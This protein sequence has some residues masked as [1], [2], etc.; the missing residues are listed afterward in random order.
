MKLVILLIGVLIIVV[1]LI[2]D[3]MSLFNDLAAVGLL[4]FCL[5]AASYF[6]A[7]PLSRNEERKWRLNSD[8]VWFSIY[9]LVLV[10]SVSWLWLLLR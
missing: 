9:L 6:I 1:G 2:R 8:F 10:T 4:V 7:W 3:G 5:G